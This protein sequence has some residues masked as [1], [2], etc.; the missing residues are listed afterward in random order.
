MRSL[1]ADSFTAALA[2]MPAPE[3]KAVKTTV[4]G[5]DAI[6][7]AQEGRPFELGRII[8]AAGEANPGIEGR[9]S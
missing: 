8:A 5:V 3:A 6:E 2:R 1:L 7:L 9:P 4:R